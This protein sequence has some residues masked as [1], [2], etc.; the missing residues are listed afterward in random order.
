MRVIIGKSCIWQADAEKVIGS[1]IR[2]SNVFMD[3]VH[4][5][6]LESIG[7]E[8]PGLIWIPMAQEDIDKCG[9]TCGVGRRTQDPE[10][11]VIAN[12]R[13]RIDVFLKRSLALPCVDASVLVFSRE[14]YLNDS[15]TQADEAEFKRASASDATHFLVALNASPEGGRSPR[16]PMRLCALIGDHG[17]GQDSEHWA[18]MCKQSYE[19]DMEYCVVSDV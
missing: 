9:V 11:Y 19:Y 5:K 14:E 6:V 16:S 13:G 18:A 1:K 7:D 12:W 17:A 10:D 8:N 4:N 2:N 3:Y 15:D